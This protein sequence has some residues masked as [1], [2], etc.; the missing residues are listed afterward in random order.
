MIPFSI[1]S[2]ES[3]NIVLL[4]FLKT[5]GQTTEFAHQ[6]SKKDTIQC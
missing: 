3:A 2:S 1:R 6:S 5:Y 4:I